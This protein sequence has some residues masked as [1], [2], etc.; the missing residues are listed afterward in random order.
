MLQFNFR[1]GGYKDMEG[2][3]LGTCCFMEGNLYE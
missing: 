3:K 1:Y 2:V